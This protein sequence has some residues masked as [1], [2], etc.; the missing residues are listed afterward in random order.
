[1]VKLVKMMTSTF[2][3][4]RLLHNEMHNN[5]SF[6]RQLLELDKPYL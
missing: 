5:H 3:F 4:T 6:S 2:D 1:M